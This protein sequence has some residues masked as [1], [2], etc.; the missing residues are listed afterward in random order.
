MNNKIY[1]I[2]NCIWFIARSKGQLL[3]YYRKEYDDEFDISNIEEET[4]LQNGFWS[5]DDM[6]EEL[7]EKVIKAI[8]ED[9]EEDEIHR[10]QEGDIYFLDKD[11]KYKSGTIKY[12]DNE[13]W[14]WVT[15]QEILDKYKKQVKEA[16]FLCSTEW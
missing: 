4:N 14:L 9:L 8:E 1:K 13:F 15:F 3:E 12:W 10:P 6:T 16:E 11:G 7:E 5:T 2:D